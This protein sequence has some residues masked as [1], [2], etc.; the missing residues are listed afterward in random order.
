MPRALLGVLALVCG[1]GYIVGI[2]QIY[3][4]S[5]DTVNKPYLPIAA[6]T[7]LCTP[8]DA[9]FNCDLTRLVH[10]LALAF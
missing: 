6:G 4:V 1:N 5:V 9:S 7:A 10:C 3:D 2:N 8:L